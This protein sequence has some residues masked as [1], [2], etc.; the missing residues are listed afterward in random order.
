MLER[1]QAGSPRLGHRHSDANIPRGLLLAVA[2]LSTQLIRLRPRSATSA[3]LKGFGCRPFAGAL[4]L[5]AGPGSESLVRRKPRGGRGAVWLGASYGDLKV[6]DGS[7]VRLRGS[8][9]AI[10]IDGN[11]G[12][13]R[14]RSRA[15]EGPAL[16]RRL[17][18]VCGRCEDTGGPFRRVARSET[19]RRCVA[20]SAAT[21]MRCRS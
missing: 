20:G 15:Y 5:G 17:E 3:L 8:A 11:V 4:G 18:R 14:V 6:A 16:A 2:S 7:R 13:E 10:L 19:E 21:V 1:S 12:D 9:A